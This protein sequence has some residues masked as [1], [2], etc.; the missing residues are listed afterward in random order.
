MYYN[1]KIKIIISGG[2]TGGHIY[3]AIASANALKQKIK[4]VEILFIGAKGKMEMEKVPASGYA[5]EGLWISG[6]QRKLTLKN[7][8]VPFKIIFSLLKAKKI[9]TRFRP[10]VVVGVGGYASGPT[11]KIAANK[12]IPTLIQE[13]NSLPGITNKLLAKKT[14]KIC[15]AYEGMERFFPS[16]KIILTGNP[17]RQDISDLENKKN[18]ALEFFK[19][20]S[21][22]KIVLILGGSLGAGKI[23]QSIKQNLSLIL[24]NN[25]QIIWQTGKYY[26]ENIINSTK[27]FE[28]K[29]LK[30][31][32]FI[33]KMD[34]A[35]AVADIV[36]SRAGAIS[37]SELCAA[38]KSVIL[39][40][41]PN[42]AE[43]HQTKNAISLVQNNAAILIKDNEAV[44]NTGYAIL[45]LI[46]NEP[47]KKMLS[48]NIK[49]LAHINAADLIAEEIIKLIK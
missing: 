20:S 30:I 48:E 46:K 24:E 44:E 2:G 10:D 36:V 25:I 45:E 42:V 13:Q 9:I 29:D 1:K 17:I 32:E 12:K 37:I 3:P 16:S 26:F 18:Q 11:L 47:K 22:K 35:L 49:K 19:L 6:F 40:P 14:D 23:N 7:L 38:G 43:D 5:I 15:V 8:L 41:S 21:N 4:D 34:Y 39:I 28:N 33:N 31:F 27:N